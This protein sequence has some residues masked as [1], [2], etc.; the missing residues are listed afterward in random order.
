MTRL[1]P[2]LLISAVFTF[3]AAGSCSP[4]PQ[5]TREV[6]G[7]GVDDDMN[8]LTDCFDADCRGK[9][10][11]IIDAGTF[12]TCAKCG[13]TCSAQAQCLQTSFFADAP[14]PVCV[15]QRCQSFEKNVQVNLTIDTTPYA[16]LVNNVNSFAVRFIK[17]KA[18]DGSVVGCAQ[19][20]AAA[21]SKLAASAQQIESSGKFVFQGVD[22]RRSSMQQGS[23]RS[24]FINVATGGDYLIW[25][26][27]WFGPPDSATKFP[28]GNRLG[29]ECFEGPTGGGAFPAIVAA[30]ECSTTGDAGAASCRTFQLVAT[31]GPQP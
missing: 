17:K 13:Q 28:T 26:E 5:S 3:V 8:G 2:V 15:G 18:A 20:E 14:I 6:C 30:D 1:V 9:P 4:V 31:R 23:I 10:E 22:I 12:G 29:Y 21:A 11:C 27:F 24:N 25:V 7:N 16:Q 19:L